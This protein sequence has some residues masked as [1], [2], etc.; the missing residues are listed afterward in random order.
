[1][2]PKDVVLFSDMDETLLDNEKCISKKNLD[3]IRTF[4]EKGGMFTVATGRSVIGFAPYRRWL[5]I[6]IPVIL[7]NGGCIY[8]YGKSKSLWKKK[9]PKSIKDFLFELVFSF[10]KLGIQFMTETTA[11]C[12]RP[13][14]IYIESMQREELLFQ[15]ITAFEDLPK[16]WLKV[17]IL[18]DLVDR[19]SLDRY[20]ERHLP[21]TCRWMS[22]GEYVRDI[23]VKDVSKGNAV[24]QYM[25]MMDLENKFI[26]CI[27]DHNNDYEMI[28]MADAGFAVKNALEH[29]KKNADYIDPDNNNHS[30]SHV[31]GIIE[32]L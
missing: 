10:P 11:Y 9:Y 15:D 3:A 4:Q 32:T 27:G 23:V 13:T 29:V 28:R 8:D 7:C 31:I 2:N 21:A 1:M 6:D 17:E 12:Y 19:E 24:R 25:K 14:P 22:T 18:A 20:L 5:A 26:C 16:E 30:I